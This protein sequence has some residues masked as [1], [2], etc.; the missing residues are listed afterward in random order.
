MK[1][2]SILCA[3]FSALL[4]GRAVAADSAP[5]LFAETYT[6]FEAIEKAHS[7]SVAVNGVSMQYL[8]WGREDG[9]PLIWLH[10]FG[11]TGYELMTVAPRL[12]AA[13]YR[14][15]AVTYRG[16][17]QTQVEDYNFSLAHIADDVAAM[18]DV[19][20]VDRAVIGGLS[21]GGGVATTFYELYPDRALAVVLVDGGGHALIPDTHDVHQKYVT[22]FGGFSYGPPPSFESR[23]AAFQFFDETL[24]P[25]LPRE[26]KP[27]FHSWIRNS[28]DGKAALHFETDKLLGFPSGYAN[29][30]VEDYKVPPLGR[31]YRR[32]D[33]LVIYRNLSAP[34]LII[35][36]T[37]DG[38]DFT[39]EYER[40]RDLRPGYIELIEYPD[41]PHAAVVVRPDWFVRDMTGLLE[42]LNRPLEGG[43]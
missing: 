41:T 40:L 18:M 19:L 10:G 5:S 33:P 8:E 3:V 24:M 43:Q 37:G 22:L 16:H 2:L 4:F 20:A 6:V 9:V 26:I 39:P 29:P 1:H 13:G 11:S 35:D 28:A 15:L 36:P 17:G 14:V 30:D 21:L 38:F 27:V 31:S 32:L 42:R 25:G 23:E 7:R 12:A 34:L